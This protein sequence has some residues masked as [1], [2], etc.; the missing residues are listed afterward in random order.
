MPRG[1]LFGRA[2]HTPSFAHASVPPA[3]SLHELTLCPSEPLEASAVPDPMVRSLHQPLARW[4]VS[5]CG[6]FSLPLDCELVRSISLLGLPKEST[7]DWVAQTTE[8][9]RL[10]NWLEV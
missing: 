7:A 5:L 6:D 8:M 10:N 4:A 2:C 1:F 9:Y 3:F